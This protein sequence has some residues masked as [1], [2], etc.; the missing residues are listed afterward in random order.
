[1]GIATETKLAAAEAKAPKLREYLVNA[2]NVPSM[3]AKG[4]KK[5]EGVAPNSSGQVLMVKKIENAATGK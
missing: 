3:E 4:W 1:M 5:K 2:D